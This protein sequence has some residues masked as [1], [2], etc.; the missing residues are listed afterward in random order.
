MDEDENSTASELDSSQI[1]SV[2]N[3]GSADDS[4]FEELV[5]LGR[6]DHPLVK[7]TR[8]ASTKKAEL[9]YHYD[10]NVEKNKG[11]NMVPL[12]ENA[13]KTVDGGIAELKIIIEEQR[14]NRDSEE[15]ILKLDVVERDLQIISM[16]FQM[17]LTASKQKD[18][19]QKGIDGVASNSTLRTI[20][21]EQ[22]KLLL[23]RSKKARSKFIDNFIC[24][25]TVCQNCR[26][27]NDQN[28][29]LLPCCFAKS[30]PFSIHREGLFVQ[31]A[32]LTCVR[33]RDPK[34]RE[35]A[36]TTFRHIA[37]VDDNEE[38]S[39]IKKMIDMKAERWQSLLS[40]L[41]QFDI[42][43]HLTTLL[44][45]AL[46]AGIKLSNE[47]LEKVAKGTLL[48]QAETDLYSE[49]KVVYETL[50]DQD[51]IFGYMNWFAKFVIISLSQDRKY[52]LPAE[53]FVF[54]TEICAAFVTIYK[55]GTDTYPWFE[56]LLFNFVNTFKLVWTKPLYD[57]SFFKMEFVKP[58]PSK[59]HNK[60]KLAKSVLPRMTKNISCDI[61]EKKINK[62]NPKI[63]PLC[64]QTC[65]KDYYPRETSRIVRPEITW[66]EDVSSKDIDE[67]TRDVLVVCSSDCLISALT[68][69]NPKLVEI[70]AIAKTKE[71]SL[72]IGNNSKT[73]DTNL[74]NTI[75]EIKYFNLRQIVESKY[76]MDFKAKKKRKKPSSQKS[77]PSAE[78]MKLPSINT[79]MPPIPQEMREYHENMLL[80]RKKDCSI[81]CSHQSVWGGWIKYHPVQDM[82]KYKETADDGFSK[83]CISFQV[84]FDTCEQID[85]NLRETEKRNALIQK[86]KELKQDTIHV[87]PS[88]LREISVDFL[89][90]KCHK[91]VLNGPANLDDAAMDKVFTTVN[92]LLGIWQAELDDEA[93]FGMI[94]CKSPKTYFAFIPQNPEEFWDLLTQKV[95]RND[96]HECLSAL[97][98]TQIC[99]QVGCESIESI[100]KYNGLNSDIYEKLS[101]FTF[102]AFAIMRLAGMKA[103]LKETFAE[104]CGM[105]RFSA[106]NTDV[107]T[108][109]NMKFLN[110]LENSLE[111]FSA[112]HLIGCPHDISWKG[113]VRYHRLLGRKT[114]AEFNFTAWAF[115]CRVIAEGKSNSGQH[116]EEVPSDFWKCLPKDL[117]ILSIKLPKASTFVSDRRPIF[118]MELG[119]TPP[120]FVA[121]LDCGRRLSIAIVSENRTPKYIVR[122]TVADGK[123][124][125]TIV[126]GPKVIEIYEQVRLK[127][128]E[129]S[130]YDAT[131]LFGEEG[132]KDEND[133]SFKR[134]EKLK[135]LAHNESLGCT[136]KS[137]GKTL[138]TGELQLCIAQDEPVHGFEKYKEYNKLLGISVKEA[139]TRAGSD[140]IGS[141]KN[142]PFKAPTG[143]QVYS[144]YALVSGTIP[145][146]K[147]FPDL[148]SNKC[149]EESVSLMALNIEKKLVEN[150]IGTFKKCFFFYVHIQDSQYLHME[151][152]DTKK[153][154]LGFFIERNE[155]VRDILKK[156]ATEMAKRL[157]FLKYDHRM[158]VI[159]AYVPKEIEKSEQIWKKI[160]KDG[161]TPI[162]SMHDKLF[163][164]IKRTEK[165]K[166]TMETALEHLN[167][168]LKQEDKADPEWFKKKPLEGKE[169]PIS[170]AITAIEQSDITTEKLHVICFGS[171]GKKKKTGNSVETSTTLEH[172]IHEKVEKK[173]QTNVSITTTIIQVNNKT[174]EKEK[175][176]KINQFKENFK[177]DNT[178]PDSDDTKNPP[179]N[180]SSIDLSNNLRKMFLPKAQLGA[181]P[182][183]SE[184]PK[185]S[186][187]LGEE[188]KEKICWNC[189]ASDKEEA[190]KLSK[191]KGCKKARYCDEECQSSDWERHSSYCEKMQKKRKEKEENIET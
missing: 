70:E 167:D 78:R 119:T 175:E 128:F 48:Y 66:S 169:D 45:S 36:M 39:D 153:T 182:K 151:L 138:W 7:Y 162:M 131:E 47:N 53:M 34:I 38:G 121:D 125:G 41:K 77:S 6:E 170:E 88:S 25:S 101:F 20:D 79:T 10:P 75:L 155:L 118:V 60:L 135:H 166:R 49:D 179:M 83:S 105:D 55:Y 64:F 80:H 190:V 76:P 65:H 126:S 149:K 35:I 54:N 159:I 104:S 58:V 33:A 22:L 89:R 120:S 141:I 191:C 177:K 62:A 108:D 71:L 130:G 9:E 129:I 139:C 5:N 86:C 123:I 14:R 134:N 189:H 11:K 160:M 3:M 148:F 100:E 92:C 28:S 158:G 172:K 163:K 12:W 109:C 56:A 137:L 143:H 106:V 124:H 122:F 187:E 27:C 168:W 180:L 112:R 110:T 59:Q 173:R 90:E 145:N 1:E 21:S 87:F 74:M 152:E 29:P 2:D 26:D 174:D 132:T 57:D 61:C 85:I 40:N 136:D 178:S 95:P 73:I 103:D 164:K 161:K 111:R 185:E 98:C 91:L 42:V 176:I 156:T 4:E 181:R 67:C 97:I 188:K 52:F 51:G 146:N 43:S 69:I 113:T 44:L 24:K 94:I 17:L 30:G 140:E 68:P 142:C 32:F 133:W 115:Q 37:Q 72:C 184:K 93:C 8:L 13:K 99:T 157:M 50:M 102:K 16:K 116:F 147:G 19:L 144:N 114:W 183:E 165:P 154:L 96:I 15:A 23:D 63:F 127:C 171:C 46:Q 84:Q 117:F 82:E 81:T 150:I 107:H 31:Y 18:D 186:V